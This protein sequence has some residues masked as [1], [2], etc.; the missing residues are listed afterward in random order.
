MPIQ[1]INPVIIG[2]GFHLNDSFTHFYT[3]C[4]TITQLSS[5]NFPL[6]VPVIHTFC[7][8]FNDFTE[9]F[10]HTHINISS[11]S[12]CEC[13]FPLVIFVIMPVTFIGLLV[14]FCSAS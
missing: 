6:S 13:F 11:S 1:K 10:G 9:P 2:G 12:M 8:G 3:G 14:Y 4:F 5:S 7:S